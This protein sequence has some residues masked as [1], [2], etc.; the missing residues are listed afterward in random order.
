M[1]A[2][3][4]VLALALWAPAALAG[5]DVTVHGV[6]GEE[7]KNVEARLGIRT[8]IEEQEGED[9]AQIRRLH[10]QAEEDIRG[11]LQ[12]YGW[13]EPVIHSE[14][15]GDPPTEA[16]YEIELGPPTLLGEVAVEVTG[17]GAQQKELTAVVGASKLRPGERLRHSDY[18]NTKNDL[19]RAAYQGGY[20][21][22]RFASHSLVVDAVRHR[23]D[24]NLSLESG[25]RYFFGEVS[26]A[27][28]GLDPEF[29]SRYVPIVPGDPFNP[30]K[31]LEAQF[32]LSDLG[33]FATVDVQPQRDK[34]NAANQIPIVISTT[35]RPLQRYDIG[36]GYGTD[37]G[38]RLPVTAEFRRLNDTGHKLRVSGLASGKKSSG[39]LD[40]R[41]PLGNRAGENLGF[42]TAYTLEHIGDG[43]SRRYDL[44]ISLSRTPGKWQ[45]QIYLKHTY[46]KSLDA[47]NVEDSTKLLL[48]GVSVTHTAID[49]PI[50]ARKGWSVFLDVHGGDEAVVSDV[51]FLQARGLLRGAYTFGERPR[52][53]GRVE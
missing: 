52:L 11:A 8:Y 12:A 43:T 41:I 38:P 24:V 2:A 16:V 40:Y 20:L 14:L 37:T 27:Q 34:T 50:H 7:L 17:P 21:D 31:L 28:Q 32:V 36:I 46:E 10:R 23:A 5:F 49:D 44:T 33:Y 15:K 25:P 51:T 22:A 29:I 39:G 48:P 18:E 9:P 53:L 45:R 6:S 26:V 19:A 30:D 1:S 13:Y 4:G 3:V 47:A 42:A 35:P